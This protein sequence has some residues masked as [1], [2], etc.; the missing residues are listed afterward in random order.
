MFIK[1][2]VGMYDS[3]IK[4]SIYIVASILNKYRIQV[5]YPNSISRVPT[6]VN[7]NKAAPRQTPPYAVMKGP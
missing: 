7:I 3:T 5:N 6:I 1:T 4:N 2:M